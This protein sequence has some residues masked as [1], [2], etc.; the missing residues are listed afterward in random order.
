LIFSTAKDASPEVPLSILTEHTVGVRSVS[1]SPNSQYLAT[2]GEVNDGFLF[3]WTVSLK[4]GSARL[5]STNKCINI[6]RHMGWTGQSL[7]TYVTGLNPCSLP[8]ARL[9]KAA[10]S[11]FD[12]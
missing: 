11:E 10:A 5:H 3:V 8:V 2:L 6:V 1:F 12:M 7:V 4:T 9:T